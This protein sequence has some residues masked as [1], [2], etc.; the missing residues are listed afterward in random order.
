[1]KPEIN[2]KYKA[3]KEAGEIKNPREDVLCFNCND[4]HIHFNTTRIIKLDPT[5]PFDLSKAEVDA[6]E[7]VAEMVKFLKANFECCKNASISSIASHVGVRESRKL[8]GEYVLTAD[9]LVSCR[10][11]DDTVA[12]GNY[13]ID[14]HNPAGTGTT[15][16]HFKYGEIYSIPYRS[17]LPR[18]YDNML[19]AGRCLS[20]THEAQAAVRV[21]PICCCMGEAAGRA[22]ALAH[23]GN[24]SV[25]EISVSELQRQLGL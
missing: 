1:M 25:R 23:K 20:A 22:A 17:L 13:S 16:H 4:G 12:R 24:T 14:I 11:F 5:D 19:V 8:A 18:E 21:M 9:D 15:L 3:A 7:Q 10:R 6:R 2:E